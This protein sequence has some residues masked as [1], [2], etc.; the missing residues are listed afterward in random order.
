MTTFLPLQPQLRPQNKDSPPPPQVVT[1]LATEAFPFPRAVWPPTPAPRTKK[2]PWVSEA[3]L[4]PR[5]GG[6]GC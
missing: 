4:P 5:V 3:F 2:R 6:G 1:A